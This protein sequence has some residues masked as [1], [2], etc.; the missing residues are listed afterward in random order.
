[1][2]TAAGSVEVW[3]LALGSLPS[4]PYTTVLQDDG[5]LALTAGDGTEYW[6]SGGWVVEGL[7]A[8]WRCLAASHRRFFVTP[9]RR[10]AGDGVLVRAHGRG[11]VRGI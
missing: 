5:W 2:L 6:R 9:W 10:V 3:S 7:Y 4:G 1:M 11:P 8:R